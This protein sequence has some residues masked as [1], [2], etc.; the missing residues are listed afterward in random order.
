LVKYRIKSFVK[1]G[2]DIIASLAS[3]NVCWDL[4]S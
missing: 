1:V 3:G 2:T 4:Q